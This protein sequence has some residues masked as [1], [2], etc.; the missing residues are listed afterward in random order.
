MA[1]FNLNAMFT[2]EQIQPNAPI[3]PLE[4]INKSYSATSTKTHQSQRPLFE[5]VRSEVGVDRSK[6]KI[7]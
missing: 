7:K 6:M 4:K 2:F 3:F 1:I 5:G